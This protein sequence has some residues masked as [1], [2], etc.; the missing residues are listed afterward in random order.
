MT[1]IQAKSDLVLVAGA[2]GKQGGAVA[3]A[4]LAMGTPVRAL[5]R[6]M[7]SEGARAIEA[8]GASLVLG[9]L[10][11]SESLLAAATGVRSV[12]SVQT[13]D[14]A[15]LYSD[16][17][18]VQGKNLVE[19]AKAA[20]VAQFVHTSVSGAGDYH[21]NA[22]GW[23]EGR[24]GRWNRHYWESKAYTEE[25]VRAAG[26]PYW[27]II[28]PASFMENFIRPSIWYAN[29]VD[30]RFLTVVAADTRLS[31]VAVQDVGTAGAA[32]ISNPEKFNK[33]DIELAGDYLTVTEIAETLSDVLGTKI[34]VL[35]LSPTQAREQGL[36]AELVSSQE[37]TNE[38]GSPARPEYAHAL[39]LTTIN[40]KTW[41]NK[42]LRPSA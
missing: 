21:R 7:H 8:L 15:D 38:V 19:A 2:T 3:R 18:R 23:K 16:S 5:V 1:T 36:M 39:G 6:D 29:G 13:P 32:V 34:E 17:E 9:N 14:L 25:L 41:A 31:L 11:D 20:H 22:P 30:D 28:K 33:M 35:S 40:F 12:F 4:L 42:T 26:F 10:N 27:T 24:W 37:W